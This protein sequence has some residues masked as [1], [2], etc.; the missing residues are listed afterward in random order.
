MRPETFTSLKPHP[1]AG[2]RTADSR[3]VARARRA[4]KFSWP[5]MSE[6]RDE[7]VQGV[8]TAWAVSFKPEST[9]RHQNRNRSEMAHEAAGESRLSAGDVPGRRLPF[10]AFLVKGTMLCHEP[11]DSQTSH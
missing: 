8:Q 11:M 1:T 9:I 3:D 5:D 6:S 7:R 4:P 10:R 2:R